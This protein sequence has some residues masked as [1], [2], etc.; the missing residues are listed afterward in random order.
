MGIPDRHLIK[1]PGLAWCGAT[2]E[3]DDAATTDLKRAKCTQCLMNVYEA[4]HSFADPKPIEERMLW[5]VS[6]GE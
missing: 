2:Y 4:R 3:G 6:T 5:F 1:S